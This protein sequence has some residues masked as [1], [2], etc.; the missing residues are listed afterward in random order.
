ME[1]ERKW[2]VAGWPRELELLSRFEMEQGYVSV[3]PTVRIRRE[4]ETGGET[5]LILCFKGEGTLSREEIE[6]EIDAD[7]FDRL[8]RLIGQP[9]IAKT[10]R[11]YGLPGGL[12]LEVNRVDEGLPTEFWYAEVEFSTEA[13]ALA[14]QPEGDLAAYLSDEVTGKPGQSMGAYWKRTRLGHK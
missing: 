10:Q 6:T 5:H 14:W 2:M 9:L 12:V 4:A 8:A 13:E 3:K 7:L 1:I 11:R